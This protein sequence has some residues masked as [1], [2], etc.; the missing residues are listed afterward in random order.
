MVKVEAKVTEKE[1]RIKLNNGYMVRYG[2]YWT[3]YNIVK[4]VLKKYGVKESTEAKIDL[5]PRDLIFV[6]W[7]ETK[8][9]RLYI[10]GRLKKITYEE[11]MKEFTE[12][13]LN[14]SEYIYAAFLLLKYG[15][16]YYE[17]I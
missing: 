2:K 16:K 11:A 13:V 5:E 14:G 7:L 3:L 4:Q 1:V 6:L 15:W 10:D 9:N 8:W 12:E 17:G